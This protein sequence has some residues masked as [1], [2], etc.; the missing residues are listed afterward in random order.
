VSAENVVATIETPKSHQGILRPER[1]KSAEL[2]PLCRETT[3]PISKEI[4]KKPAIIDQSNVDKVILF[5]VLSFKY[6][7]RNLGDEVLFGCIFI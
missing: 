3:T 7:S 5:E 1:K 2:L 4:T 6:S